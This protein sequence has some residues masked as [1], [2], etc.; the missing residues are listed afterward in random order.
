MTT[1]L[2]KRLICNCNW[3]PWIVFYVFVLILL[4]YLV[5]RPGNTLVT[6]KITQHESHHSHGFGTI[7]NLD[8]DSYV[9]IHPA[10]VMTQYNETLINNE[11][12]FKHGHTN[13]TIKYC[14]FNVLYVTQGNSLFES[15]Y[16]YKLMFKN[17]NNFLIFLYYNRVSYNRDKNKLLTL[18]NKSNKIQTKLLIIVAYDVNY[19]EGKNLLL[20]YAFKYESIML[21]NCHF[22]YICVL[23]ADIELHKFDEIN[24]QKTE[25]ETETD[26]SL[27]LNDFY[28]NFLDKY[29]PLIGVPHRIDPMRTYETMPRMPQ[30]YLGYKYVNTEL[31]DSM[32][33]YYSRP[34]INN[35]FLF[36]WYTNYDFGCYWE[37]EELQRL[38]L[39]MLFPFSKYMASVMYMPTAVTNPGH[40]QFVNVQPECQKMLI[41][42]PNMWY[43]HFLKWTKKYLPS[44]KRIK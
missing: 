26:Y 30:Q 22:N 16:W 34:L 25:L 37:G 10:I 3:V 18:L 9:L 40:S 44:N 14:G 35:Y 11:K 39:R 7:S 38:K 19:Y 43:N 29:N 31:F 24:N 17:S 20:S 5:S 28:F 15:P 8:N 13:E 1:T 12:S 36:P 23:D 42:G 33:A 32:I 27:V 6:H 4:G 21:N 41:E 2:E